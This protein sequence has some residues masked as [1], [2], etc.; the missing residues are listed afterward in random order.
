MEAAMARHQQMFCFGTQSDDKFLSC[1][2]RARKRTEIKKRG[3]RIINYLLPE[4][5]ET[6]KTSERKCT[7][8]LNEM[9]RLDF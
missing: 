6:Q 9:I 8:V 3:K 4:K 7:A 5:G 1:K 2:T